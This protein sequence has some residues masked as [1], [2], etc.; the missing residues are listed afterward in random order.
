MNG[1]RLRGTGG[2]LLAGEKDDLEKACPTVTLTIINR[3]VI[4]LGSNKCTSTWW[5]E[6]NAVGS[7]WKILSSPSLPKL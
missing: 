6:R 3:S 1:L 7:V 5:C 4:G 2:M